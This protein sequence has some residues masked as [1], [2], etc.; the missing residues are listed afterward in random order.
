M[1]WAT[2]EVFQLTRIEPADASDDDKVTLTRML[3]NIMGYQTIR[4]M[5]ETEIDA[6]YSYVLRN[7]LHDEHHHIE[8]QFGYVWQPGRN[9]TN[10]TI[11]MLRRPITIDIEKEGI[12]AT[13]DMQAEGAKD[14]QCPTRD[15]PLLPLRPEY[16]FIYEASTAIISSSFPMTSTSI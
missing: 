11:S 8:P 14:W 7:S 10:V 3:N 13:Y 15:V 1:T 2:G 5:L 6:I 9:R 12:R 16:F 4:N